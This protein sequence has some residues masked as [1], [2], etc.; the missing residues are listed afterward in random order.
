MRSTKWCVTFLL[1]VLVG[2][3]SSYRPLG[4]AG[5]GYSEIRLADDVFRV[6]FEGN[7]RTD[8]RRTVDFVLLRSAEVALAHG[9]RYF[10]IVDERAYFEQGVDHFASLVNGYE[11]LSKEPTATNTILCLRE[12]ESDSARFIYEAQLVAASIRT[13]YGI[14]MRAAPTTQSKRS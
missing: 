9:F 6:S 10:L 11:T 14:R 3:A 12:E 7:G 2:C 13:K 1:A 8:L 4:W 5:G